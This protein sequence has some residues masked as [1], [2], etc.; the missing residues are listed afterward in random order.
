MPPEVSAAHSRTDNILKRLAIGA[1]LLFA[2]IIS[3]KVSLYPYAQTVYDLYDRAGDHWLQGESAYTD[4]AGYRYTPGTTVL[5]IPFSLIPYR[6]GG[7]VWRLASLLVLLGGLSYWLRAVHAGVPRWP[8]GARACLWLILLPLCIPSVNNGQANVLVIG[9]VLLTMAA[10]ARE[11]WN[12]SAVCAVLAG[13]LKV[14]PLAAGMLLAVVYPRR[15]G[16]RFA[17]ALALG[18]AAPFLCQYPDFVLGEYRAWWSTLMADKRMFGPI[19]EGY[20]DLWSLLRLSG[21]PITYGVYLCIQLGLGA[22]AAGL[23]LAARRL[24][25]PRSQLLTM[26]TTQSVCWMLLCGP[27]TEECTFILASPALA[28]TVVEAWHERQSLW[29]RCFPLGVMAM[30]FLHPVEGMLANGRWIFWGLLP[31]ATLL[32][33]LYLTATQLQLILAGRGRKPVPV[34]WPA[35]A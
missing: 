31:S 6:F 34:P 15:F 17:I 14:Y 3:V 22:V 27:A 2:L 32:L 26:V 16:T 28:W 24:A 29:A 21:V 20:R 19:Q 9:L 7:V 11:R 35:A 8:R 18:L 4:N 5:F 25:L 13:L 1:W 33:M 10:A 23:C 12:V 30:Y